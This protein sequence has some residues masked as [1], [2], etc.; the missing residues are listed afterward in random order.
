MSIREPPEE[1]SLPPAAL[2]ASTA[3]VFTASYR[4]SH[5]LRKSISNKR[6]HGRSP[7]LNANSLATAIPGMTLASATAGP[8]AD[9]EPLA[10]GVPGGR[11]HRSH[12][13]AILEKAAAWLDGERLK[14]Q[15]R[16]E[17]KRAAGTA[18]ESDASEDES[19]NALE[20]LLMARPA[21]P[22]AGSAPG[23][24]S[25]RSSRRLMAPASDTEYASDGDALVPGCEVWL[26]NPEEIG[27]D[28]FRLEV[29]KLTHTLR[30]KG[31]RRV[32]LGRSREV[33]VERLSG[34]LT[35]AVCMAP[36]ARGAGLTRDRSTWSRRRRTCRPRARRRRRPRP[37]TRP[38]PRTARRRRRRCARARA[39]RRAA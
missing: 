36:G 7:S 16:R 37:S 30:C 4:P 28:A 8:A 3:T 15:L 22:P 20:A 27:W 39:A 12:T 18:A 23:S 19:L 9:D 11:H 35:N 14:R 38:R 5:L 13:S 33:G 24:R 26:R 21:R 1:I 17:K 34:A 2:A 6:L 10:R 29:L 31:W 32:D 25:R